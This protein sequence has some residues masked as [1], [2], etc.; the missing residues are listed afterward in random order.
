M[1]LFPAHFHV[2][3]SCRRI[4]QKT[5]FPF[6]SLPN[7]ERE[8]LF[9][10]YIYSLSIENNWLGW[11]KSKVAASASQ[12]TVSLNRA[13]G[14]GVSR[15][16]CCS[17]V[18]VLLFCFSSPADCYGVRLQQ[19]KRFLFLLFFSFALGYRYTIIY[20]SMMTKLIGRLPVVCSSQRLLAWYQLWCKW[21]RKRKKRKNWKYKYERGER[22]KK[23]NDQIPPV[24]WQHSLN[25]LVQCSQ[26]PRRD[27]PRPAAEELDL[28][29]HSIHTPGNSR[30][31]IN[32]VATC[33]VR[34]S[35][36]LPLVFLFYFLWSSSSFVSSVLNTPTI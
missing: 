16:I 28:H 33:C 17:I 36:Y 1:F 26:F 8:I 29:F 19:R 15:L 12:K 27:S 31:T 4:I 23:K 3:N 32:G 5:K 6:F 24:A 11:W 35:I 25:G 10:Y 9:I 30:T 22:K 20:I 2:N 13:A 14:D 18:S 21:P 7:D 34:V